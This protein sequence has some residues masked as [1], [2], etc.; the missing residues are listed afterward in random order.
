MLIKREKCELCQKP[1]YTH[2]IALVCNLNFKIYHAKCLKISRDAA[3]E[4]QLLPDWYC[5]CCIKSILP[6]FDHSYVDSESSIPIIICKF[7]KKQISNNLHKISKCIMCCNE[8]HDSC[9]SP[10]AIC[11]MCNPQS[12]S[13]GALSNNNVP[14]FNPFPDDMDN[15]RNAYFDDDIDTYYDTLSI[16][17]SNLENCKYYTPDEIPTN[18]LNGTSFYFHNIDGFKTNFTEFKNQCLNINQN[19]DFYCFTESNLKSGVPHDF[20]IHNYNSEMVYSIDKKSK[21]SGLAIIL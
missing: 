5:P 18:K 4:I 17:K 2:N 21:G 3:L 1:I 9:L 6:F 13:V 14:C 15:E 11:S 12:S 10:D 20:H 8:F 19:F 16:V 7:C